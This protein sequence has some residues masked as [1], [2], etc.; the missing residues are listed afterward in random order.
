MN[1]KENRSPSSV[2]ITM[3]QQP[4][5]LGGYILQ[6]FADIRSQT[7][8]NGNIGGSGQSKTGAHGSVSHTAPSH[9][10][11]SSTNSARAVVNCGRG[12]P[13]ASCMPGP[14]TP[15]VTGTTYNRRVTP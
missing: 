11:A 9:I 5:I 12:K 6:L 7:D 4:L 14:S 15:R 8:G 2:S 10:V 13:Y 1:L 3:L